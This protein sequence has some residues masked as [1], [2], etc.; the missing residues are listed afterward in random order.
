MAEGPVVADGFHLCER[1]V[2]ARSR[3]AGQAVSTVIHRDH[4]SRSLQGRSMRVTP[5][6]ETVLHP[7][8]LEHGIGS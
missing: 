2:E 5:W 8:P 7:G 6:Q 3:P 1:F 4:S